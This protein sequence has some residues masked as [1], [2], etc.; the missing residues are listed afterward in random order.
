MSLLFLLGFCTCGLQLSIT[1]WV[2]SWSDCDNST[3]GYLHKVVKKHVPV[4]ISDTAP[5]DKRSNMQR[6]SKAQ[7]TTLRNVHQP[8]H[9]SLYMHGNCSHLKLKQKKKNCS[10]AAFEELPF[11]GK[12]RSS[13][14][15]AITGLYQT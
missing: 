10:Q 3:T 2:E 12:F 9:I 4:A 8:S 5:A 6:Y 7:N 15:T 14:R 13:E 1:S 11:L